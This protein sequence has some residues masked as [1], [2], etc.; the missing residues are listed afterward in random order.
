[1]R[2]PRR[3]F[4]QAELPQPMAPPSA[5][6]SASFDFIHPQPRLHRRGCIF[7]SATLAHAVLLK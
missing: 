7:L 5:V 6:K 4:S 1:M 3:I 2:I